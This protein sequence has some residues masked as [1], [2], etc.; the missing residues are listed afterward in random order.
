MLRQRNVL[1][2]DTRGDALSREFYELTLRR[3]CGL[4]PDRSAAETDARRSA[5][6][7]RFG[8]NA[9]QHVA[10]ERDVLDR[11]RDKPE[12][13]ERACSF[14][15]AHQAQVAPCRTKADAAAERRRTN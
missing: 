3:G 9:E 12:R 6:G 7:Q 10:V 1:H 5:L 11:A 4:V 15:H 2:V 13:I 14:F 8:F